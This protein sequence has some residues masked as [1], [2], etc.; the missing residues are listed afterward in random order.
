MKKADHDGGGSL[1][2]DH[3]ATTPPFREAL[4][5]FTQIQ[6]QFY[7]NPSSL[8]HLGKAAQKEYESLKERFCQHLAFHDGLLIQTASA[9]ESNNMV[10]HSF[11]EQYPEGDIY[12][13]IDTHA[14][15]WYVREK[16]PERSH[17]IPIT[18]DGQYDFST[19]NFLSPQPKLILINYISQDLGTLH[20]PNK[21]DA[22]ALND[23]NHLHIDAT[24]AFG[25]IPID[26][27]EINF[28]S[29]SA[30]A[31]KFGGVRGCGLLLLRNKQLSPMIHGGMQEEQLRAGTE[32]IAAFAAAECAYTLSLQQHQS[33]KLIQLEQ[34][35]AEGLKELNTPFILNQPASKCPGINNISFPGYQG[36]E[37]VSTLS[38]HD[39]C[40]ATGSACSESKTTASR[41]VLALGRSE[42][43]AL[44]SLRISFGPHQNKSDIVTLINALKYAL[45]NLIPS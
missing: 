37:L 36:S 12:V 20:N 14:S 10:V 3:A 5:R 23:A 44:G 7:A 29:M 28:H 8:H 24:Q 18:E 31:H 17:S 22:I 38:L 16:Y 11:M 15:L 33:Q 30:S 35:L 1:Y 9:T 41:A 4:K 21:W 2:F 19:F 40:L 34:I 42:Y 26:T 45:K 13:G 6:E 25:K 39:I 32:N 43:E 27:Q